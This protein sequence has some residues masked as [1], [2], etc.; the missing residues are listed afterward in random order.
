[1][2]YERGGLRENR[3]VFLDAIENDAMALEFAG[4][5]LKEDRKIVLKA[6]KQQPLALQF[7]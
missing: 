6:V 7:A 1:M 3:E 4:V 5:G 2:R